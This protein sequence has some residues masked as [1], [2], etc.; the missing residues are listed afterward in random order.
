MNFNGES[1]LKETDKAPD[2]TVP[3]QNGKNISLSDYKGKWVILYFYPKDMT[4]GCTTE[5]C[6]FRDEYSIFKKKG[7]V[8]LGISKDSVSS[9]KKF[10][11]KYELPFPLLSDENG[12]ICE[13]YGVWQEKSMYGKKYMGIVRATF[14]ITPERMIA[15]VYPK[16]KVKEHV[17]EILADLKNLM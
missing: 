17:A 15:K 7:I 16:V 10:E 5:A 9:H 13:E 1:M 6:N 11:G 14:I 3:D 8:V 2:F 12:N 4:P